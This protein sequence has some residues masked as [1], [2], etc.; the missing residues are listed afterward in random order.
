M[1]K[2]DCE[3]CEPHARYDN[4]EECLITRNQESFATSIVYLNFSN[5]NLIQSV[6]GANALKLDEEVK[7]EDLNISHASG[8]VISDV[9]SS[10]V[11]QV[12]QQTDNIEA[13]IDPIEEKIEHDCIKVEKAPLP[14]VSEHDLVMHFSRLAHRNFAVDLGF[15]PLGS[16]TMKYNPRFA[17]WVASLPG[18]SNL[19]P[20]TPGKYSQGSLEILYKLEELSLIHI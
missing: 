11:E 20:A 16:C 14:E 5:E 3:S 9:A 18:F 1:C 15:Y 19:H 4:C 8:S 10:S 12:E 7:S 17:D 13:A 2:A 6:D